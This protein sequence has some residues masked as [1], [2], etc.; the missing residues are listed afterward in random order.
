MVSSGKDKKTRSAT[1]PE[2]KFDPL[3]CPETTG[4]LLTLVSP[5]QFPH[6]CISH[7][8]CG[9]TLHCNATITIILTRGNFIKTEEDFSDKGIIS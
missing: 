1:V 6:M 4:D 2:K 7:V 8:A 9:P 5:Y 3:P